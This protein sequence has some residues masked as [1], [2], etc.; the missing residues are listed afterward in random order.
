MA[1]T[2]HA[3]IAGPIICG[4]DSCDPV[5]TCSIHHW[6]L[7]LYSLSV[8]AHHRYAITH[9]GHGVLGE[10]CYLLTH[11]SLAPYV[12]LLLFNTKNC[13]QKIA[14]SRR[15]PLFPSTN[16]ITV[17]HAV[18]SLC[19]ICIFFSSHNNSKFRMFIISRS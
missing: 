19:I 6:L 10:G 16:N 12:I 7:C 5:P 11:L 17:S 15:T 9:K 4:W 14:L 13:G 3:L 1:V 8:R 2:C 18:I